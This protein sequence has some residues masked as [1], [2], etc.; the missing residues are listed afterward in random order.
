MLFIYRSHFSSE[1]MDMK[2]VNSKKHF[3]IDMVNYRKKEK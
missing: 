3:G 2:C 1:I